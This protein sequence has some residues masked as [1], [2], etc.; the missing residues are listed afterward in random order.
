MDLV[1]VVVDNKPIYGIEAI[2]RSKAAVAELELKS[3]FHS[4]LVHLRELERLRES[5][6]LHDIDRDSSNKLIFKRHIRDMMREGDHTLTVFIQ[7]PS[8]PEPEMI[9]N[10]PHNLESKLAYYLE[11]YDEDMRLKSNPNI[12]MTRFEFA[13]DGQPSHG[14]VF[15]KEGDSL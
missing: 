8:L 12:R 3:G 2:E 11:A 5:E 7:M 1:K 9:V 6:V 13:K 14:V 15:K 10:P 4:I